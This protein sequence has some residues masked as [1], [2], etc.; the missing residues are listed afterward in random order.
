MCSAVQLATYSAGPA[1]LNGR[2][3]LP[4]S[5]EPPLLPLLLLRWR[6]RGGQTLL[7]LLPLLL[8]LLMEWRRGE[9]GWRE[10]GV[11]RGRDRA[12]VQCGQAVSLIC[13]GR[14][15]DDRG[16]GNDADP[17]EGRES[18]DGVTEPRRC[19]DNGSFSM[20]S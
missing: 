15:Q 8:L 2:P 13:G 20:Y 1:A 7:L 14:V 19:E 12:A 9:G 11:M 3:E 10:G 18:R 17:R 16:A 5:A 6:R 4:D